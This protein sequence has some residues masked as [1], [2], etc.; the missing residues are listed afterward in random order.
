[1][2]R[3]D[4]KDQPAGGE[5]VTAV[6]QFEID[7]KRLNGFV[8]FRDGAHSFTPID[9]IKHLARIALVDTF[10]NGGTFVMVVGQDKITIV[11]RMDTEEFDQ[12]EDKT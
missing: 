3:E 12:Q 1:V 2:P 9:Q 8:N 6:L 7:R 11:Q 10:D 4:E 5:A